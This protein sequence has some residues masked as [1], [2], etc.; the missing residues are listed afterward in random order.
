MYNVN[1]AVFC[2]VLSYGFW[3]LKMHFWHSGGKYLQVF[4][5]SRLLSLD[6]NR[7]GTTGNKIIIHIFGCSMFPI[8]NAAVSISLQNVSRDLRRILKRIRNSDVT[9]TTHQHQLK[10]YIHFF[11]QNNTLKKSR[12]VEYVYILKQFELN[13]IGQ[14]AYL[15]FLQTSTQS[16]QYMQMVSPILQPGNNL[17]FRRSLQ[18]IASVDDDTM[19]RVTHTVNRQDSATD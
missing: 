12:S 3:S 19:S 8:C 18:L 5:E 7:L 15:N 9:F 10:K 6:P 11:S 16:V 17:R 2:A 1:I 13:Q 4:S 14:S